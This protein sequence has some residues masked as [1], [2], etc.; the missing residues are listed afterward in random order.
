MIEKEN[1][2]FCNLIS[3]KHDPIGLETPLY[4]AAHYVY[5]IFSGRNLKAILSVPTVDARYTISNS[6]H[7]IGDVFGIA[8]VRNF[9][10]KELSAIMS[11]S[12]AYIGHR[13]STVIAD[14]MT[15]RGQILPFTSRG[16]AAGN[17][18][19]F[20]LASFDNPG[21]RF[22]DASA[23]GSTQ[24]V[25][26][27][28]GCIFTGV[29]CHLGTG[30]SQ[31]SINKQIKDEIAKMKGNYS[32]TDRLLYKIPKIERGSMAIPK[33]ISDII[34]TRKSSFTLILDRLSITRESPTEEEYVFPQSAYELFE[35]NLINE[36]LVGSVGIKVE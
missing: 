35:Q 28:A 13:F 11:K 17:R 20:S 2:E 1:Q 8:A 23:V 22:T 34:G 29:R 18:G 7:E 30:L 36:H 10:V 32:A 26:T 14:Y 27:V 31:L 6:L 16:S 21:R 12:G 15:Y 19:V 24:D 5:A 3:N 4:R 25:V 33:K 9:V